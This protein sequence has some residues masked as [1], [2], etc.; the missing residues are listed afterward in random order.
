MA[1]ATASHRRAE[2]AAAHSRRPAMLHPSGEIKTFFGAGQA[3]MV[4][5]I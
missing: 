4:F 5:G 2:A 1:Q 3:I